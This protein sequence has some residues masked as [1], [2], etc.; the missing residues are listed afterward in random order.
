MGNEI[1]PAKL[2][3]PVEERFR[4]ICT[5]I[6]ESSKKSFLDDPHNI[7][8]L[9]L[10][11]KKLKYFLTMKYCS[12]FA[13]KIVPLFDWSTKNMDYIQFFKQFESLFIKP[14]PLERHS[15]FLKQV[16]FSLLDMNS[17]NCL[18]EYDMFSIIKTSDDDKMFLEAVH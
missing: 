2:F 18:C 17:D 6:E 5:C 8:H 9:R 10:T 14:H 7:K 4:E 15:S 1:E 11:P 13:D 3:E 12:K 16:A